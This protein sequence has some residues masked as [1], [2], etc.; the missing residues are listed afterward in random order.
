MRTNLA[1]LARWAASAL[2]LAALLTLLPVRAHPGEG[3]NRWAQCETDEDRARWSVKTARDALAPEI[4]RHARAATVERLGLLPRPPRS[5]L[6]DKRLPIEARR[7]RVLARLI[8]FH[9]PPDGDVHVTV[10][11]PASGRRMFV[12]FPSEACAREAPA[13]LGRAMLRA[14]REAMAALGRKA[15]IPVGQNGLVLVEGV[16][17]FDPHPDEIGVELHPVLAFRRVR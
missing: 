13:R 11:D 4:E 9:L 16:L 5:R 8:A 2:T 7:Y 6:G 1:T 14:R 15:K 3:W 17:F 12:E 10:A